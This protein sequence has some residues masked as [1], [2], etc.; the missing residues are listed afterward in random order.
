MK[1]AINVYDREEKP[2]L[3]DMVLECGDL[4]HVD[5]VVMAYAEKAKLGDTFSYIARELNADDGI[6]EVE[7]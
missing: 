1:V 4:E 3:R 7:W 5:R 6:P 2:R